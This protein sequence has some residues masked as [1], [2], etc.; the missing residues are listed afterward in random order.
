MS[1]DKRAMILLTHSFPFGVGEEFIEHEMSYIAQRFDLTIITCNVEDPQTRMLPENVKVV[2]IKIPSWTAYGLIG[3]LKLI[4]TNSVFYEIRGLILSNDF[5]LSNLRETLRFARRANVWAQAI[6]ARI[7]TLSREDFIVYSYWLWE[8]ALGAVQCRR[9]A[10]NAVLVSRAHG[11]DV[12]RERKKSNYLPFR[13]YM[14]FHVNS[15]YFCSQHGARYFESTY[16][17]FK[18]GH[19]NVSYLGTPDHGLNP[20]KTCDYGKV[21]LFSCSKLIPLKRVELI[22]AALSM[23]KKTEVSWIHAGDGP[24]YKEI[25]KLAEA[26][27][28]D[29][30]NVKYCFLGHMGNKVLL[31]YYS[32]HHID[33]FINVSKT[34]GLP[35]TLM[36]AFSFGIPAIATSVGGVPEIVDDTCGFLIDANPQV[37]QIAKTIEHFGSLNEAEKEVYRIATR[38]KWENKFSAS[39]NFPKFIEDISKID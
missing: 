3:K 7:D 11:Y 21:V 27:L 24:E 9:K 6:S 16:G 39:R 8:G 35:V 26:S 5:S 18:K 19:I 17:P 33:L 4:L 15:I 22:V 12:Y 37:E 28:K 13:K 10:K 25:E 2:R 29:R 34:E 32:S 30:N 23:V 20:R 31:E 1:D 14:G 38:T 36:E